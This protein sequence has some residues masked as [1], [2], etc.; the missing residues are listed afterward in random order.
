VL[1]VQPRQRLV[2]VERGLPFEAVVF[3]KLHAEEGVG[4]AG[5]VVVINAAVD[6]CRRDP[7]AFHVLLEGV[8]AR[9]ER[10][11]RPSFTEYGMIWHATVDEVLYSCPLGRGHQ[12]SANGHLIAPVGR[13]KKGHVDLLGEELVDDGLVGQGAFDYGHI[14]QVA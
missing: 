2:W 11:G 5:E 8:F 10:Q 12:C 3:L 6:E 1:G 13:I 9:P 4:E 14:W 7:A